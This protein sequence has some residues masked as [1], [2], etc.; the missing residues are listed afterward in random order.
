MSHKRQLKDLYQRYI[1]SILT[2]REGAC[3]SMPEVEDGD[4]VVRLPQE[5]QGSVV[6]QHSSPQVTSQPGQILQG[7]HRTL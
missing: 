3:R 1:F 2:R 6:H 4:A 5:C 7:C